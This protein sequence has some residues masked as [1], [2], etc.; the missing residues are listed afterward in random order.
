M[1]ESFA[2]LPAWLRLG[3]E[4]ALVCVAFFAVRAFL[5][6]PTS[7]A[8]PVPKPA[9]PLSPSLSPALSP[10]AAPYVEPLPPVRPAISRTITQVPRPQAGERPWLSVTASLAG[11][12]V[13]DRESV[14]IVVDFQLE[15]TGDK[16]ALEARL[17]LLPVV[18][19]T[20]RNVLD[21]Q[22]NLIVALRQGVLKADGVAPLEVEPGTVGHWSAQV[23]V[24]Q[25][26]LAPARG[27]GQCVIA[28]VGLVDYQYAGERRHCQTGFIFDLSRHS[29]DGP[30]L[31]MPLDEQTLPQGGLDLERYVG[32]SYM[33]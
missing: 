33:V 26:E 18:K 12:L 32:G 25:A 7:S 13:C 3:I 17:H 11:D 5:R 6:R 10:P 22:K 24:A 19:G 16:A 14:N 20:G 2:A 15:N 31:P 4:F 1:L 28:L 29:G 9:P 30:P 23:H 27:N 8:A 21:E